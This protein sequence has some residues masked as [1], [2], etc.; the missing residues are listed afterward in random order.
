MPVRTV[1]PRTRRAH[2]IVVALLLGL[3]GVAACGPPAGEPGPAGTTGATA[4]TTTG[5]ASTSTPTPAPTLDP[6]VAWTR[7]SDP[8]DHFSLR[9]P[10]TWMQR[11]CLN[12]VHTG[13][14]LA[15]TADSLGICNS[16]FGGQMSVIAVTGDERTAMQLSGLPDLV[17]TAVTVDG[18]AG[19]RQ[20]ATAVASELGPPAGTRLVVYVFFIGGRTYRCSYTQAPS[21]ATSADVLADFDLMVTRTLAF[22]A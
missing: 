10:G 3:T 22:A 13:L 21:G 1:P 18:Q 11:T 9:Y 5:P 8:V 16:G 17:T 19:T 14:F 12:G 4:G 7:Y 15:P 20:S 6:T 2:R